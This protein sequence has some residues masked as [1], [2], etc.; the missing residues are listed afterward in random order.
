MEEIVS[1]HSIV[2]K[3][4]KNMSKI[5]KSLSLIQSTSRISKVVSHSL[6]KSKVIER[7]S[8][9]I[10]EGIVFHSIKNISQEKYKNINSLRKKY[11][12]EEHNEPILYTNNTIKGFSEKKLKNEEE[13]EEVITPVMNLQRHK[14]P[15]YLMKSAFIKDKSLTP[16]EKFQNSICPIYDFYN[17]NSGF[18]T[19]KNENLLKNSSF[20]QYYNNFKNSNKHAENNQINDYFNPSPSPLTNLSDKNNMNYYY[21]F[22]F[23]AKNQEKINQ[24][25]EVYNDKSPSLDDEENNNHIMNIIK[26]E[27]FVDEKNEIKNVEGNTPSN[28]GGTFSPS[29]DLFDESIFRNEGNFFKSPINY[30][31]MNVNININNNSQNNNIYYQLPN[32][33]NNFNNNSNNNYFNNNS[34]NSQNN[35][36]NINTREDNDQNENFNQINNKLNESNNINIRK[37]QNC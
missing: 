7:M 31:Q 4:K 9:N 32:I 5:K 3:K 19:A 10:S 8:S 29:D 18:N 30:K 20:T 36:S 23:L 22:S 11:D 24:I 16:Q 27:N 15:N 14:K 17:V 13:E 37:Q 1:I 2:H 25:K 35:I 33:I 12:F 34:N 21:N 28:L 26:G 6:N